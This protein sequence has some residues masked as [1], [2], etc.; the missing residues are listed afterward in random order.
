M[1]RTLNIFFVG[2][3]VGNPG[4]E[5]AETLVPNYLKKYNVDLLII[6]GENATDGKGIAEE[7]LPYVFDRFYRGDKSRQHNGESGLGLAIAKSIIEAHGGTIR[8]ESIPDQGAEFT[9]TLES[10]QPG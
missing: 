5:L 9:I 6:N 7:D 8:V 2:D 3:I 1:P 4:L 10:I